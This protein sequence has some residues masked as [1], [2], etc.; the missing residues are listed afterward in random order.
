[1]MKTG[2]IRKILIDYYGGKE[3]RIVVLL[4]ETDTKYCFFNMDGVQ[5]EDIPPHSRDFSHELGVNP[6][7]EPQFLAQKTNKKSYLL[8]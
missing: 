8:Y 1:M 7:K 2:D 5:F 4:G 6:I 3:E